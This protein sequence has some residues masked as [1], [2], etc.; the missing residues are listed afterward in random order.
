MD[1]SLELRVRYVYAVLSARVRFLDVSKNRHKRFRVGGVQELARALYN[2]CQM[3][4]R[5]LAHALEKS[6]H[7]YFLT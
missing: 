3:L 1:Y 4:K 5:A 2:I 6:E 7:V